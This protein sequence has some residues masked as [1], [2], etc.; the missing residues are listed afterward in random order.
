MENQEASNKALVKK[1]PKPNNIIRVTTTPDKDFFKW[2]CVLLRPFVSLTN[3]EIDVIASFLRQRWELANKKNI[4]DPSLLDTLLMSEDIKKK[5]QEEC[6]ITLQ[7]FYVIMS[8]LKKTGVIVNN[9]IHPR[10]IPN[11]K[12]NKEGQVILMI[13]FEE[14]K[15]KKDDL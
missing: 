4:T 2:W 12:L 3:K 5:V 7:H 15:F 6:N 11:V 9:R 8:N 13:L 10:L 1:I 14:D